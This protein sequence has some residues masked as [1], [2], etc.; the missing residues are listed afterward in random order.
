M[1]NS[2]R[3]ETHSYSLFHMMKKYSIFIFA[4]LILLTGDLASGE[5]ESLSLP[6]G[7]SIVP[8]RDVQY[9]ESLAPDWKST[10]DEAR[11]LSRDKKFDESLIKY[12]ML[13]DRKESIEEARWEYARILMRLKKWHEATVELEHL[14][15]MNPRNRSFRYQLAQASLNGNDVERAVILYGQL[16]ETEA[17]GPQAV[18]AL[19]GL[20]IGLEKQGLR[21]M[22]LPFLEQLSKSTSGDIEI[23]K[24]TALVAEEFKQDDKAVYYYE[25]AL[26]IN[27]LDE[28]SLYR[29][30]LL[31]ERNDGEEITG[32]RLERLSELY[33]DNLQAN[34]WLAEYYKKKG[35]VTKELL[36]LERV[37]RSNIHDVGLLNRTAEL[38]FQRGRVDKALTYYNR[39]LAGNPGD[40][41]VLEK[42]REIQMMIA[43]DLLA[44]VENTDARLLWE[45][46]VQIAGDRL[47]I[48]H[49]MADLLRQGKRETSLITIL[50]IIHDHDQFDDRVSLELASLLRKQGRKGE[51]LTLLRELHTLHPGDL[52]IK[53]QLRLA[54]LE[55]N[56]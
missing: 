13:L 44:I 32:S 56:S 14:V 19:K 4:L 55:T 12:K 7:K 1:A 39:S 3:P 42:K 46:L 31:K 51:L 48:F 24:K 17:E 41:R 38:A 54:E 27:P 29:F 37:I 9:E 35:N 34:L 18:I 16:Y 26:G 10:W 20:L 33:P 52:E 53:R 11:R 36:H 28:V 49:F 25:Q 47:E 21:K 40:L 2:S 43:E 6:S 15:A 8:E 22:M 50:S 23:L 45:D 5:S 30:A